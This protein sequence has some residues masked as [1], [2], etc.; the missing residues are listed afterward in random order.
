MNNIGFH[1]YSKSNYEYINNI[2]ECVRRISKL[3]KI[4]YF[5]LSFDSLVFA[6]H[7]YNAKTDHLHKKQCGQTKQR[8][9]MPPA[10]HWP[11]E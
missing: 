7:T 11:L 6:N 1:T 3:M 5:F 4:T 2:G 10:L 9:Y 8:N